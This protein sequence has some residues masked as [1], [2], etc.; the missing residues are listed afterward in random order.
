M[1]VIAHEDMYISSTWGASIRLYADQEKEVGDDMGLLALQAGARRVEDSPLRNPSLIAREEEKVEEAEIVV[2]VEDN[3]RSEKLEAAIQQIIDN[4][5]PK[6]FTTDGM[7]KQSVIKKV[8]GEQV[9][10]EERDETW[11]KLIVE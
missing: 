1:K 8:F 9:T 6:D 5:D 10:S 7:P 2:E 11:A 3:S 4:G